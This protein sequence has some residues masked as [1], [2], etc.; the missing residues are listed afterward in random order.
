MSAIVWGVK[1]SFLAYLA[2]LED[3]ETTTADGATG[4]IGGPFRWPAERADDG[5][6]GSGTVRFVAHGGMLDV[7]IANPAL[8]LDD[9]TAQLS[10]ARAG[11]RVVIASG[12][13]TNEGATLAL[14]A[15]GGRLLGDVYPPGTPLDDLTLA[16]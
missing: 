12:T 5:W 15:A 1:A 2:E 7:R 8:V 11:G 13:A 9:G 3:A 16:G 10:V 4:A 14:T 6:H